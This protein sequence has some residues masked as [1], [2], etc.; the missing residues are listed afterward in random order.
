M[1]FISNTYRTFQ[2]KNTT[3]KENIFFNSE[4]YNKLNFIKNK[5]ITVLED[6][7]IFSKYTRSGLKKPHTVYGIL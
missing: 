3:K 7:E 2:T 5:K 4:N 6:T 1:R